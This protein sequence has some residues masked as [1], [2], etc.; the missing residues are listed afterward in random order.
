MNSRQWAR[1][2]VSS[3]LQPGFRVTTACTASPQVSWGM[4][5]TAHIATAGWRAR[6]FSTS[7]EYTFSPPLTIMSFTRSTM[8]R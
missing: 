6:A 5:I 4:P 1:N 7:A 2:S 3:A 8:N